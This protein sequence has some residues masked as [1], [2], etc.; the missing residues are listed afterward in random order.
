MVVLE[1]AEMLIDRAEQQNQDKDPELVTELSGFVDVFLPQAFND[2]SGALTKRLNTLQTEV[3]EM[4]DGLN[5]L[6]SLISDD[7][8]PL[9]KIEFDAVKK[10]TLTSIKALEETIVTYNLVHAKMTARTD[11]IKARH[12]NCLLYTSPSPRDRG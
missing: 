4:K 11:Q 3:T 9:E 8:D 7:T 10:L 1:C 5:E 2:A 6:S 12:Q